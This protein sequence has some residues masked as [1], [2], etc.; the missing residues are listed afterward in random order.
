MEII[1]YMFYCLSLVISTAFG[2]NP[3]GLTWETGLIGFGTLVLIILIA[4]LLFYCILLVNYYFFANR[5]ASIKDDKSTTSKKSIGILFVT[6]TMIIVI[7]FSFNQ[8]K[9]YGFMLFGVIFVVS[10]VYVILLRIF[11]DLSNKVIV[12]GT[13]VQLKHIVDG[14][15]YSSYRPHYQY[16]YQNCKYILKSQFTAFWYKRTMQ[17]G[18]VTSIAINAKNPKNA[19][20]NKLIYTFQEY[21]VGIILIGAGIFI[22]LYG[23][24]L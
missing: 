10:G 21:L 22:A 15:G 4:A 18:D 7:L 3:D 9:I 14:E 16:E 1:K 24:N 20:I 2:N 6:A 13:L 12:L 19:R 8:T 17:I 11:F 5:P 23:P